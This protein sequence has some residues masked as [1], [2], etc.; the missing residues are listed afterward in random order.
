M[1]SAYRVIAG[2]ISFAVVV[3]AASIAYAMFAI[4]HEIEN[5]TVID[6]NYV[7]NSTGPE[8]VGFA[9][10]AIDGQMVIPLLAIVLLVVSFF[11]K[12][13]GGV[14]WAAF[15]LLAVVVQVVLAFVSFGA[16]VVGF[17]HGLNALVVFGLAGFAA[18]R[19][20][21]VA[22]PVTATTAATATV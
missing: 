18:R 19:A 21:A 9:I 6:K 17:L 7:E 10:H 16:P 15:V 5:G 1:R 22:E 14:R 20:T 8:G 2:L 13:A 12:V 3:Q 11:A 4:S